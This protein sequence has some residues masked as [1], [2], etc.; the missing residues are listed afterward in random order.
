M[1]A[2]SFTH[3]SYDTIECFSSLNS[4]SMIGVP[5]THALHTQTTFYRMMVWFRTEKKKKYVLRR[6]AVDRGM[7]NACG[8]CLLYLVLG[9]NSTT[10]LSWRKKCVCVS[11]CLYLSF[12]SLVFMTYTQQYVLMISYTNNWRLRTQNRKEKKSK[13]ST[14]NLENRLILNLNKCAASK[15]QIQMTPKQ[16]AH[17]IPLTHTLTCQSTC[18]PKSIRLSMTRAHTHA[19]RCVADRI[20]WE[21]IRNVIWIDKNR[22][23]ER[24]WVYHS[25][26]SAHTMLPATGFNLCISTIDLH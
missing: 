1:R 23:T 15:V 7:A 5:F 20:E 26:H 17:R 9:S 11:V 4:C 25:L 13:K 19:R 22:V 24:N 6:F 12:I 3:S 21:T 14:N 18:P 2:T 16:A 10:W 8:N